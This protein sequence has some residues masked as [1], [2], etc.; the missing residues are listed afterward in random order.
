MH[1]GEAKLGEHLTGSVQVLD[2]DAK[3]MHIVITIARQDQPVAT[4]EQMLLHVDTQSGRVC[5][6]APEVLERLRPIRDAHATLPR[7]SHAGRH[8]GQRGS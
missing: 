2:A 7:P 1:L 5:T 3:R 8:V 6:A 4:V